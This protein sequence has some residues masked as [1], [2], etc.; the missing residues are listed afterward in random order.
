MKRSG[1]GRKWFYPSTG[2]VLSGTVWIDPERS[3][4][5]ERVAVIVHEILHALGRGHVTGV[6][7]LMRPTAGHIPGHI[8]HDLDRDVLYA[9]HGFIEG[10]AAGD[11]ATQLGPWS[12]TADV[13]LGE[14]EDTDIRF[15]VSTRNGYSQPWASGP[16]PLYPLAD[17]PELSGSA[18]W[19]GR[20]LGHTPGGSRDV[21]GD[22]GL[23]IDLAPL[24]GTLTFEE[25]EQ[26]AIYGV[27]VGTQWG[28]GDLAYDVRVSGN[29]L[30]RTGGD[31]GLLTG[32]FFGEHDG[33]G[34]TLRRDD[35]FGAFGGTLDAPDAVI[36]F[37]PTT[38]S[39][40][41]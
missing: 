16:A 31:D 3:T 38:D 23:Q 5:D 18:T 10:A 14:Y 33:I 25:L 37:A 13:L 36:T 40:A 17:N 29:Y 8:L 2:T 35:L 39:P 21:A 30:L 4:G 7:S 28:D 6:E 34:G 22:M 9:V 26:W 20:F 12:T 41:P 1:D 32:A 27:G 15:G 11:T 24:T 19:S